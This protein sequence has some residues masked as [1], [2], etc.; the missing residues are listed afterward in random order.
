ML[1][2]PEAQVA[3]SAYISTNYGWYNM[4][5]WDQSALTC[6]TVIYLG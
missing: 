6:K 5:G 4:K 3:Y 2:Y 1:I